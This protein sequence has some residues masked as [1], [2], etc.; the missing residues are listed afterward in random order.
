MGW[1]GLRKQ[2]FS[3]EN[4]RIFGRIPESGKLEND[5]YAGFRVF[6][7][8][9]FQ[10]ITDLAKSRLQIGAG[11]CKNRARNGIV[12]GVGHSMVRDYLV[13]SAFDRLEL[14][15]FLEHKPRTANPSP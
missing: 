3:A 1:S 12:G 13:A 6:L 4:L 11:Q 15:T 9:D 7:V 14:L 2:R 10:I 5:N 8:L